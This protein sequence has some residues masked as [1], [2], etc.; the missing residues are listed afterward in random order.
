MFRIETNIGNFNN[1]KHLFLEMK[2]EGV[3]NV[4]LIAYYCLDKILHC[5]M[6]LSDVDNTPLI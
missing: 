1:P 2:Y 3:D 4:D 6:S 5:T